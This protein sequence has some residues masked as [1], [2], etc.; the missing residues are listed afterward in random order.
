SPSTPCP[1]ER[2]NER[3][4]EKSEECFLVHC[5]LIRLSPVHL[6]QPASPHC[7]HPA[8]PEQQCSPL[9]LLLPLPLPLSI[10]LSPSPSLTHPHPHTQHYVHIPS[11]LFPSIYT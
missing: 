11:H 2:R 1:L 5:F 8:S 9:V 3:R 7:Q 4:G 10:Y 6:K